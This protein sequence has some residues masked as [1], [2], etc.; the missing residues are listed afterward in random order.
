MPKLKSLRI[1]LEGPN[2]AYY[3]GQTISGQ[4]VLELDREIKVRGIKL[5]MKGRSF[6]RWIEGSG[7]NKK[8][9]SAHEEYFSITTLL[10]GRQTEESGCDMQIP[11]GRHVYKFALVLPNKQ[12]PMSFETPIGH[13]RYTIK[14]TVDIPWAVDYVTTK[15]FTVLNV[16]DLNTIQEA[17]TP[18]QKQM[19]KT[20][21]CL[22]CVTGPVTVCFRIDKR[23]YAPGESILISGEVVNNSSRKILAITARLRMEI[24]YHANYSIKVKQEDVAG[25][26]D[27]EIGPMDSR[28]WSGKPLEV[29]AVPAS[30]LAGC[31]LMDIRY[32]LQIT[33]DVDDTPFDLKI[34]LAIIVGTVPITMGT[35]G[36]FTQQ[37]LSVDLQAT[38]QEAVV[39][40]PTSAGRCEPPAVV[41]PPPPSYA[42]CVFGEVDIR[43]DKNKHGEL[44]YTPVY[45]FYD[46]S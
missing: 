9:K 8:T 41:L 45:P 46:Y 16:L 38:R 13:V 3:P 21:C 19:S 15:P 27:K 25:I 39:T 32:S 17:G 11:S 43:D 6:V 14:A 37:S 2:R 4:L 24:F 23:G 10:L 7:D 44:T 42:E 29:P 12:L 35:T 34:P 22:C 33:T 28:M 1:V 30:Y 5:K 20:L 40:Q 36:Q 18:D 31:N 26:E